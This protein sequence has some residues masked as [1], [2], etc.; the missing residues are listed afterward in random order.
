LGTRVKCT[1]ISTGEQSFFE[2]VKAAARAMNITARV[3]YISVNGKQIRNGILWEK[4]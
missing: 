4:V 2:S 1:N 3:A